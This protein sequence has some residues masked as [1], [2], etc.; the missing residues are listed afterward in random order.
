MNQKHHAI[1]HR[2]RHGRA[3]DVRCQDRLQNTSC[4][5]TIQ[6]NRLLGQLDVFEDCVCL[7]RQVC[8][9]DLYLPTNPNEH[10]RMHAASSVSKVRAFT[11]F[12]RRNP[13]GAHGTERALH[14]EWKCFTESRQRLQESFLQFP[15]AQISDWPRPLGQDSE[16]RL[17]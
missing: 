5:K 8:P 14:D 1:P 11:A 12:G 3:Q 16:Q 10:A 6:R 17:A 2:C 7:T 15:F 13:R 4:A 9:S